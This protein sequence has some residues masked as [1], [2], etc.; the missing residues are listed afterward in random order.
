MKK[1]TQDNILWVG[2][3]IAVIGAIFILSYV[4]SADIQEAGGGRQVIIDAGRCIK[5]IIKEIMEE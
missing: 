2:I 4:I 5:D 1:A 3:F